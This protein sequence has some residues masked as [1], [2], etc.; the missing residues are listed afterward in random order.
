MCHF[1]FFKSLFKFYLSPEVFSVVSR[2]FS[3]FLEFSIICVF[4]YNTHHCLTLC[5]PLTEAHNYAHFNIL[6]IEM[7]S[8]IYM[9]IYLMWCCFPFFFPFCTSPHPSQFSLNQ[10]KDFQLIKPGNN[11]AIQLSGG[12][13]THLFT[14]VFSKNIDYS[15]YRVET[16]GE[17]K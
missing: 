1:F 6:E 14:L 3:P 12:Q 4:Y 17:L 16:W 8:V 11:L 15:A 5:Y 9:Y 13:V 10:W 2:M 7:Y